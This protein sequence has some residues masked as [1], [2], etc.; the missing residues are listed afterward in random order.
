MRTSPEQILVVT[1]VELGDNDIWRGGRP[2]FAP[3]SKVHATNR[4]DLDRGNSIIFE[5]DI[6]EF[7]VGDK[8][9][10]TIKRIDDES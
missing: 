8:I 4:E 9:S 1:K 10:V 6:R 3:I 5:A 2:L 7:Q